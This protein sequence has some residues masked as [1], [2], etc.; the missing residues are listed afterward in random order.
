MITNIIHYYKNDFVSHTN[1]FFII[2]KTTDVVV[3]E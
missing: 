2:E 3:D 1:S